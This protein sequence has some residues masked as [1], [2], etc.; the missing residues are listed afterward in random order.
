MPLQ[1]QVRPAGVVLPVPWVGQD[2]RLRS[3][4]EQLGVDELIAKRPL[5]DPAKPFSQGDPGRAY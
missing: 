1:D 2:L 3:C 4:G 5:N